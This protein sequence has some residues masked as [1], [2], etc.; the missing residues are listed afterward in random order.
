E[1]DLSPVRSFWRCALSLD[2]P[3]TV[4]VERLF[5]SLPVASPPAKAVDLLRFVN[6]LRRWLARVL[7]FE[8][9]WGRQLP[10]LH[11]RHLRTPRNPPAPRLSLF[12]PRKPHP[13]PPLCV[14]LE[15]RRR[16]D[17][18]IRALGAQP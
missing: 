9:R 2:R 1:T 15:R 3:R 5:P 10:P 11:R 17:R 16:A 4:P 14:V 8:S 7:R 12:L 13:S 18:H 6:C